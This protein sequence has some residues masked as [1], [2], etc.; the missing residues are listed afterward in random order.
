MKKPQ[1]AYYF[2][3]L[4]YVFN[5]NNWE[6]LL[7]AFDNTENS[8]DLSG[9][10]FSFVNENGKNINFS[11]TYTAFGDGCYP[12]VN[13]GGN[14]VAKKLVDLP[15]DSGTIGLIKVE[16][17]DVTIDE[18]L[19][20][21][22]GIVFEVDE[23]D[24]IKMSFKSSGHGHFDTYHEIFVSQGYNTILSVVTAD[25]EDEDDEFNEYEEDE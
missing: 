16:D 18:I 19:K 7:Q 8:E 24:K 12:F 5:N 23:D 25:F 3:D 21:E 15:V 20:E 1:T 2:G 9:C 11:M 6:K 22:F 4:C 13:H 10:N 14:Y 17:C